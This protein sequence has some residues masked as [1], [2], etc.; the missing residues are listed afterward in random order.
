MTTEKVQTLEILEST[1]ITKL[2]VPVAARSQARVCSRSPAEI[3]GSN[4]AGC[5]DVC[6]LLVLFVAFRSIL[7]L[8]ASCQQ[9]CMIYTIAV[10]TVKNSWWWT[11]ELF[12]TCRVSFQTK[13][14]E[15]VRLVGFIVR[16]RVCFVGRNMNCVFM[17]NCYMFRLLRF[18]IMLTHIGKRRSSQRN[19]NYDTDNCSD[20]SVSS[21]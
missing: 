11:E 4:L 15:L 13:F 20:M 7:I 12:E 3:V 9:T 14:G 16:K 8:L 2:P 21:V 1:F 17:Q 19:D 18:N 10:C 5:M 6:L